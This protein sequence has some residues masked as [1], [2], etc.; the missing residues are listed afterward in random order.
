MNPIIFDAIYDLEVFG[1]PPARLG[2]L[3]LFVGVVLLDKFLGKVAASSMHDGF[4]GNGYGVVLPCDLDLHV[5]GH[6]GFDA[7]VRRVHE[8]QRLKSHDIA[9]LW[10]CSLRP[11]A[12]HAPWY[13]LLVVRLKENQ[14]DLPG[15]HERCICFVDAAAYLHL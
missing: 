3:L 12:N 2:V 7:Y 13:T 10:L 5:S 15:C 8:H 1:Q 4:D 6:A 9:T 14:R 11:H